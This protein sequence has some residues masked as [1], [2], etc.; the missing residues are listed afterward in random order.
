[1][2]TKAKEEISYGVQKR[3][4]GENWETV[5]TEPLDSK[6]SAHTMCNSWRKW[7]KDHNISGIEYRAVK[8]TQVIHETIEPLN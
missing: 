3:Y 6:R 5:N 8:V 1:M 2:T 4:E 7:L